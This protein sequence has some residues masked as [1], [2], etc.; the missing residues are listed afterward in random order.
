MALFL[1]FPPAAEVDDYLRV[2][3]TEADKVRRKI[4]RRSNL[5]LPR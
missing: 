5:G 2:Q 3:E 1:L 4:E